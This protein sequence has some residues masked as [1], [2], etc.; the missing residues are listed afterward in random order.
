MTK[1][2][3]KTPISRAIEDPDAIQMFELPQ[4]IKL[5]D[6][7][8]FT[9][10]EIVSFKLAAKYLYFAQEDRDTLNLIIDKVNKLKEEY[11]KPEREVTNG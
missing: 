5:D 2:N 1:K 9:N 7:R 8:V 4:T 3:N 11:I 10:C 6:G